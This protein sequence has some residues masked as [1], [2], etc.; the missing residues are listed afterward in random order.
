MFAL[1]PSISIHIGERGGGGGGYSNNILYK[2]VF[3]AGTAQKGGG[4]VL[5]AGTAQKMG[6]SVA[7]THNQKEGGGGGARC[8]YKPEIGICKRGGLIGTEVVQKGGILSLFIYY[9]HF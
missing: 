6:V 1:V 4:G 8:G 3:G 7:D 9:L 2:G 5:G